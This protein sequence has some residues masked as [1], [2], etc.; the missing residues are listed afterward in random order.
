MRYRRRIPFCLSIVALLTCAML[1]ML[2]YLRFKIHL[3]TMDIIQLHSGC[4]DWLYP[5]ESQREAWR[6]IDNV[7]PQRSRMLGF[8]GW[9]SEWWPRQYKYLTGL[10]RIIIPIWLPTLGFATV[11]AV[12]ALRLHRVASRWRR[13]LCGKCGYDQRGTVGGVCPECGTPLITKMG[14]G[15]M[16][17][18]NSAY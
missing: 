18:R 1:W 12:L 15:K 9:H 7:W 16:L 6:S 4:I 14:E 17:T 13:G 11:A 3:P 8:Q 5:T 2:S 10:R